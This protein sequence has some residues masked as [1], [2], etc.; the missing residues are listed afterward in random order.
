VLVQ[1]DVVVEAGVMFDAQTHSTV[2]INGNVLAGPGW[3]FADG[4]A[5]SHTRA[6]AGPRAAGLDDAQ[7]SSAPVPNAF[8]AGI[9]RQPAHNVHP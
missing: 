3:S 4:A 1:H 6:R 5:L 7:L 9:S 8:G 2:T